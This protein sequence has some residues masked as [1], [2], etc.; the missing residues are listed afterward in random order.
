METSLDRL[1]IADLAKLLA[2]LRDEGYRLIGPRVKDQAIVYDDIQSV[3]DLPQGWT[4]EQ[5]KGQYRLKRRGDQAYFGY[6]VGPHSWKQFL[7]PAK[8]RLWRAKKTKNGFEQIPENEKPIKTAFIGARSCDLHAIAIQDKVFLG[9]KFSDP[10]YQARRENIFVVA[11]Q[12]TQ[13]ANTCFCVSM[14]TGPKATFGYDLALTEII[15]PDSHHFI[16]EVGS[17]AGAEV[18]R[19]LVTVPASDHEQAQADTLLEKTANGMKR[20]LDTTN[21]KETLY[22]N[23]EHSR[24]DE[25]ANRCLTCSNCTMVCPTCFCSSVEDVT[26]LSGENTERVRRWDSCFTLDHSYLHGGSIRNST[27]SRYR[28]WLT[29]KV[30]SWIDQFGTSGCVGC[31]RCITWCPVGIDLTEE[32]A[33]IQKDSK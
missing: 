28:Q 22:A 9:E 33:A 4:D 2:V 20:E 27:K 23:L 12:C 19:K 15:G 26:D 24:W 5:E 32:I 16:L 18:A 10:R 13:S 11:V 8:E 17:K 14:K 1:K 29:H 25:V 3:S 30:A 31:G 6:N 7:F 21:I